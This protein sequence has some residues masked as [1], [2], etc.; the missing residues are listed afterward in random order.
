MDK[1]DVM[2]YDKSWDNICEQCTE[3]NVE[4]ITNMIEPREWRKIVA[5]EKEFDEKYPQFRFNYNVIESES[6]ATNSYPSANGKL[7]YDSKFPM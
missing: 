2:V 5:I 7:I 6:D 4:I 1:R 3:Y